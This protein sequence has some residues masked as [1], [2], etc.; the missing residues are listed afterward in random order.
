MTTR[1]VVVSTQ[2]GKVT[3]LTTLKT[4]SMYLRASKTEAEDAGIETDGMAESV[5]KLRDELMSLTGGKVDIMLDE[6]WNIRFSLNLLK[7][8]D[9]RKRTTPRVRRKYFVRRRRMIYG[10]LNGETVRRMDYALY[11]YK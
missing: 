10:R 11:D 8:G 4:L 2:S 1:H 7:S 5:S 9:I 6:D 3:E